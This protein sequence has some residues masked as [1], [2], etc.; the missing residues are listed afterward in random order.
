MAVHNIFDIQNKID[1]TYL[2]SYSDNFLIQSL[3]NLG[4]RIGLKGDGMIYSNFSF[5]D[6]FDNVNSDTKPSSDYVGVIYNKKNSDNITSKIFG[7]IDKSNITSLNDF[8]ETSVTNQTSVLTSGII[9]DTITSNYIVND[10]ESFLPYSTII[11]NSSND[12]LYNLLFAKKINTDDY[13][14]TSNIEL[15]YNKFRLSDNLL[16]TAI[17]II[18]LNYYIN[19]ST[20]DVQ[21][22]YLMYVISKLDN[23]DNKYELKFY[24]FDSIEQLSNSTSFNDIF[25]SAKYVNNLSVFGLNNLSE[26]QLSN[27]LSEKTGITLFNLIYSQGVKYTFNVSLSNGTFKTDDDTSIIDNALLKHYKLNVEKLLNNLSNDININFE[28]LLAYYSHSQFNKDL[29]TLAQ[30]IFTNIFDKISTNIDNCILY[31]PLDYKINVVVNSN[32]YLKYYYSNDFYC[33]FVNL[34]SKNPVEIANVFKHPQ[35]LLLDYNKNDIIKVYSFTFNYNNIYT[36]L[37]NS[38]SVKFLYGLPTISSDNTWEINGVDTS[39]SAVGENAGNP[40]LIIN[41]NYTREDNNKYHTILSPTNES[42]KKIINNVDWETAQ[43]SYNNNSTGKVFVPTIAYLNSSDL[44]SFKYSVILNIDSDTNITTIWNP[45]INE[46]NTKPQFACVNDPKN[47]VNAFNLNSIILQSSNN[48]NDSKKYKDEIKNVSVF[49]A[50]NAVVANTFDPKDSN[51]FVVRNKTSVDYPQFRPN[52]PYENNLNLDLHY[53]RNYNANHYDDN[54]F[55]DVDHYMDKFVNSQ[56]SDKNVTNVLYQ[57]ITQTSGTI[58]YQLPDSIDSNNIKLV[59]D[60]ITQTIS[61]GSINTNTTQFVFSDNTEDTATKETVNTINSSIATSI[62]KYIN[63]DTRELAKTNLNIRAKKLDN[64][65]TVDFDY[66]VS[67]ANSFFDEYI[68]NV[69]IPTIDTKEL[70]QRNINILN[71]TNILGIGNDGKIYNSYFGTSFEDNDKSVLHIGTSKQNINIGTGTL[72]SYA[73]T[74]KFNTVSKLSVDLPVQC[75]ETVTTNYNITKV[76]DNI[77]E[78]TFKPFGTTAHI[79]SYFTVD[80][81]GHLF[82]NIDSNDKITNEFISLID[83]NYTTAKQ[84]NS[85]ESLIGKLNINE[86]KNELQNNYKLYSSH[87]HVSNNTNTYLFSFNENKITKYC[88]A[89]ADSSSSFSKDKI[90]NNI[91]SSLNNGDKVICCEYNK[92][93]AQCIDLTNNEY[94]SICKIENNNI[95]VKNSCGVCLVAIFNIYDGKYSVSSINKVVTLSDNY[96]VANLFNLTNYFNKLG[97]TLQDINFDNK[98]NLVKYGDNIYY[99][100]QDINNFNTFGDGRILYDNH[101]NITWTANNNKINDILSI[102]AENNPTSYNVLMDTKHIKLVTGVKTYNVTQIENQA[103]IFD[104]LR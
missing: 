90:Q 45:Q 40:N 73:N 75:N 51:Y 61:F 24:L 97:F 69:N 9:T 19:S 95:V 76:S 92:G 47:S 98:N 66:A 5:Y 43:Y 4:Q 31:V 78:S 25:T 64:L 7:I 56:N 3:A 32:N 12:Y 23:D 15:Q 83:T 50:Y 35:Y 81:N 96:N 52:E 10:I 60:G 102:K 20:T 84:E 36:D 16:D 68:P 63:N 93:I 67:D 33:H 70:L 57:Q 22:L 14:S 58:S 104:D 2:S 26:T 41:Y 65:I 29:E 55:K 74:L 42:L 62:N 6:C 80:N 37:V 103:S 91:I 87:I 28:T 94:S 54:V 44:E 86:T 48:I 27:P 8:L 82:L 100:I 59:N 89:K 85:N 38:I 72:L 79:S 49:N 11:G 46:E 53:S 99:I 71:R 101:L 30:H 1:T 39:I 13:T 18:P 77:Y 34:N 88:I 17:R 21:N